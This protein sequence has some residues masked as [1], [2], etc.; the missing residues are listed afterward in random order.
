MSITAAHPVRIVGAGL[1]GATVAHE[2][3]RAGRPVEVIEADADWGGQLRTAAAAGI[4]YEPTGAH[5]FH[6]ADE[7]VW[8]LVNALV[9][10]RP[11]RHRVRTEVFGRIMSWPPQ[12]PELRELPQW[13]AIER[14]LAARPDAPAGDNLEAWCIE[15]MGETLYREYI[16]GYTRK[17]WGCEPS[18]L[19]AVWA[20]RRIE[21]RE[22]GRLDLFRDPHQGWPE[23]GYRR[24]VDGLLRGVPVTLGTPVTVADWDELCAGASAVVL[25]CA[26][27]EFFADALGPLAWRGVRFV[28]RWFPDAEHVLPA[29]VLNTPGLQHPH[30]RA[31]ETKWMSGQSGPGTMVSYEY[32]NA[33]ERH[34]PVDDVQGTNRDLHRKYEKLLAQLPGPPRV[35]AGRLA[36]YTYID[37][38]QAMRQG[39]NVA[40]RLLS[41]VG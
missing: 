35:L 7:E 24:L 37:M 28:H 9:P 3:R 6:T 32:P 4:L 36:T 39:I 10:M 17:Q 38:D 15:L 26:L 40:R 5:I 14:E 8:R 2:L 12:L 30:T 27:D 33:P 29:G 22:D 13:P 25:T 21:L 11:Y 20:P 23:G 34:Y 18:E 16:E 41:A 31:I 1:A 19:A